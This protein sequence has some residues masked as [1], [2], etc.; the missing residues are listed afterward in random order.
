MFLE[1]Q[2]QNLYTI[3]FSNHVFRK[4]KTESIHYEV[5][6]NYNVFNI[7]DN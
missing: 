1:K 3:K 4:I 6:I 2:R 7:I 5:M